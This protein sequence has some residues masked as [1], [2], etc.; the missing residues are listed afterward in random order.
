[1]QEDYTVHECNQRMVVLYGVGKA[2]EEARHS[3]KK[4]S[5]EIV[6]L[7]S[8]RNCIDVLSGDLGRVKKKKEKE[9]KDAAAIGMLAYCAQNLSYVDVL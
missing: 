9:A 5:K 2:R 8:K 3:L 1:M 6:K 7:F 4:T